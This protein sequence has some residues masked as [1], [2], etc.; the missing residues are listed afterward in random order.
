MKQEPPQTRRS[1]VGIPGVHDGEGCQL[2]DWCAT[3]GIRA[4]EVGSGM[5]GR[6]PKLCAER[7]IVSGF[8]TYSSYC[9]PLA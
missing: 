9:H 1:R 3:Q 2:T 6:R 5:N 7:P 8:F 4:D